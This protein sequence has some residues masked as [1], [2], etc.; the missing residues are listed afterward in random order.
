LGVK[1]VKGGEEFGF[2]AALLGL[3]FG[4]FHD[5]R[6]AGEFGIELSA[7]G[8]GEDDRFR[9]GAEDFRELAGD[10]GDVIEG[11]DAVLFGVRPQPARGVGKRGHGIAGRVERLAQQTGEGG[12]AG[13]GGSFQNQDGIG[14]G[15]PQ[16]GEHP[17]LAGLP[18]VDGQTGE[19]FEEAV[20]R[21]TVGFG[22]R[23]R[24]RVAGSPKVE[25]FRGADVPAASGDFDGIAGFVPQV[26]VDGSRMEARTVGGDARIQGTERDRTVVGPGFEDVEQVA[27]GVDVGDGGIDLLI[28]AEQIG[29]Q[30]RRAQRDA[31][32]REATRNAGE[33]CAAVVQEEEDGSGGFEKLIADFHDAPPV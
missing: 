7:I 17:I 10:V 3:D 30:F 26:Q 23:E 20:E 33:G 32:L 8:H 2:G 11:Q 22:S 18:D 1:L 13:A 24:A 21:R 16:G 12:F 15:G 6:A 25:R 27:V 28:F 19:G 5:R 31:R 9:G 14:A 4:Q 29:A